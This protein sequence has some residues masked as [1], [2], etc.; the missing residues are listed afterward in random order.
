ML[1]RVLT[2]Q[3]V[4][5]RNVVENILQV[6]Y[7]VLAFDETQIRGRRV[8]SLT[9]DLGLSLLQWHAVMRERGQVSRITTLWFRVQYMKILRDVGT[10]SAEPELC[11][12]LGLLVIRNADLA[13]PGAV[14][15][16][17]RRVLGSNRPIH[18]WLG[19]NRI[20]DWE[21]MLLHDIS[22]TRL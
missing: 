17:R 19:R 21:F 15:L 2:R 14:V 1:E 6:L 8:L 4:V 11:R 5:V 20:G 12:G 3:N 13:K 10:L 7:A 22:L 16:F 18:D 9:I